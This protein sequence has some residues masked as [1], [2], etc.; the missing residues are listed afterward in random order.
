MKNVML[1]LVDQMRGDTLGA[2][3]HPHVKTPYLDTLM[4]QNTVSFTNAYS[5]CP[6]CVP[7]RASLLSGMSPQKNGRVGYQ[8]G[9]PWEFTDTIAEVFRDHGFQTAVIGKMHSY[10]IRKHF[11]FE[12]MKLHDG[13]LEYHRKSD[14]PY[15]EHQRV[16]DD[17]VSFLIDKYGVSADVTNN[18]IEGNSWI[19]SPWNYDENDHP[20]NWVVNETLETLTK[21]DRTRPFFVMPSF[22]R[23][24]PPFDAPQ[25]YFDMYDPNTDYDYYEE[26]N[27]ADKEKTEQYGSI[28]DSMFG[29]KDKD[30]RNK[31]MRGYFATITHLDHQISRLITFLK[32]EGIYEDTLI[33]FTSDHG[34]MLFEHGLYRKALPYEGSANV[35]LFIR[36]GKNMQEIQT[37]RSDTVTA[38]NDIMPTL[39][40]FV[41]ID[42]PKHVD[43]IS[44][45]DHILN[46]QAIDRDY[47]HGEHEYGEYSNHFIVSK[48]YKYIWFS[49]TGREQLFDMKHD[50]NE[51][52]DLVKQESHDNILQEYRQIL[53]SELEGREEGFTDGKTLIV[54]QKQSAILQQPGYKK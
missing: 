16:S 23:P 27:W 17:Y 26:D 35:P 3:G 6:T 36:V 38:L 34:E 14:V 11:G 41:G 8:D 28:V 19:T 39:L 29:C 22:V 52:I 4:N 51:L 13:Y 20:T 50:K 9:V 31:A 32:D 25:K 54:G 48:E 43:G 49:Q 24:H 2:M 10:P 21:R 47:V 45:R 40:D 46:N 7:A 12:I 42:I 18:G 53:I 30:L 15:Y 37:R 33:L 1:I 44:L 5:T